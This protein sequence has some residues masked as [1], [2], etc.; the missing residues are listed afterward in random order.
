MEMQR[1]ISFSSFFSKC[2]LKCGKLVKHLPAWPYKIY[3]QSNHSTYFLL[4]SNVLQE[5]NKEFCIGFLPSL[6]KES[7]PEIGDVNSKCASWTFN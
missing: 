7:Y 4:V 1:M 6:I 2:E 5:S 3:L